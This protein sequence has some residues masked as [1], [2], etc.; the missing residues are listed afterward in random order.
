MSLQYG[1]PEAGVD[2]VWGTQSNQAPS[3][4]QNISLSPYLEDTIHIE[5]LE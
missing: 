1:L 4:T 5:N 3:N 2:S